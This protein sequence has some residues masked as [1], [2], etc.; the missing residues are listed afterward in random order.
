MRVLLFFFFL[1]NKIVLNYYYMSLCHL[2]HS[3][4]ITLIIIIIKYDI[5]IIINI[6][7]C[8][9]LKVKTKKVIVKYI[10]YRYKKKTLCYYCI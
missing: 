8:V 6:V 9:W 1:F 7:T 4:Y 10:I 3:F 2:T 5:M